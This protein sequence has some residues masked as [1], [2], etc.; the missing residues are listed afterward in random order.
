M[1]Y[2]PEDYRDDPDHDAPVAPTIG[3]NSNTKAKSTKAKIRN[4]ISE[5]RVIVRSIHLPFEPQIDFVDALDEILCS[6]EALREAGLGQPATVLLGSSFSGK[7]SQ[8]RIFVDKTNE[9]H[10]ASQAYGNGGM[11]A[12]YVKLDPDGTIG[13]LAG[14]ILTGL[15]VPKPMS[16]SAAKRWDRARNEIRK[17]RISIIVFDEFQRAGRRPTI[18]P[19][20]A[21][22]I[23]D[24][25][26]SGDCAVAF[27]GKQDA[28]SIFDGCPDLKNRFDSPVYIPPLRWDMDSQEFMEFAE[29]FD[30][31]LVDANITDHKSGFADEDIAQ[32]LLESSNGLIGQFSRIVETAVIAITREGRRAITR[33]DLSNAVDDWSVANERIGKNPFN[34]KVPN[35]SSFGGAG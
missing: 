10:N 33:R 2:E 34:R 16:L 6:A 23:L 21:A 15:Q 11:C 9:E 14:D 31:A 12:C 35:D 30:Q 4:L 8:T 17:K 28:K 26:D 20:I 13:S 25:M 27:V 5:R 24:I 3:H 1:P 32:L 18:S 7:S 22:K 29:R 19:I